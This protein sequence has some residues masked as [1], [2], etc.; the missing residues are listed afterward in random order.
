MTE[1]EIVAGLKTVM[2]YQKVTLAELSRQLGIPYRTLQ[3]WFLGNA[4]M[5]LAAYYAICCE[6]GV[7]G[8]FGELHMDFADRE[9]STD[10]S[11]AE[12]SRAID[13]LIASFPGKHAT[14]AIAIVESHVLHL[15]R[16][17]C[18]QRVL[19]RKGARS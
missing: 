10:R 4:S 18:E 1:Q 19:L 15:A 6:L 14:A 11:I 9:N 2:R 12:A 3:N 13:H 5:T 7:S 16:I 8:S 17:I